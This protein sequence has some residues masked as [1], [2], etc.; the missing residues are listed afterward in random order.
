MNTRLTRKYY[1]TVTR[2]SSTVTTVALTAATAYAL[3]KAAG[4]CLKAYQN[5]NANMSAVELLHT[6]DSDEDQLVDDLLY[7]KTTHQLPD[8]ESTQTDRPPT[9]PNGENANV[10]SDEEPEV[11][12][13]HLSGSSESNNQICSNPSVVTVDPPEMDHLRYEVNYAP[14]LSKALLDMV[15][16]RFGNSDDTSATRGAIHRY[17]FDYLRKRRVRPSLARRITPRVVE[18]AMIPTSEEVELLKLGRHPI[19][20]ARKLGRHLTLWEHIK[21][22]F[23]LPPRSC[24]TARAP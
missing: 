2:Y 14:H 3:C 15:K 22:L 8:T 5:L 18:M 17:V 7:Q 16:C 12:P 23:Y 1:T 21:F 20:L 13:T 11:E 4:C 24:E 9:A 6:V 10:V 19:I